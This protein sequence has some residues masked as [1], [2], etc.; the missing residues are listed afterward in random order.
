MFGKYNKQ[1]EKEQRALLI[2]SVIASEE[3]KEI[4]K[5]AIRDGD[6]EDWG[7]SEE[8]GEYSYATFDEDEA[9]KSVIEALNKHL[10]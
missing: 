5:Q 6:G 8:K 4:I 2:G 1:E 3:F 7:Y 9:T 10:L